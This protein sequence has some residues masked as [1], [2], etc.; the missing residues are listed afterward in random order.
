[1]T[2]EKINVVELK[3]D[4]AVHDIQKRLCDYSD[5]YI[6][7]VITEIADS[8]VDIYYSDLFE[9]A[10]NNWSYIDDA[11]REFGMPDS[12][13]TNII[14]KLIQQGQFYYNEELL[15]DDLDNMLLNF[16][17]SYLLHDL[18]IEEITK[19]QQEAIEEKCTNVDNNDRLDDYVDFLNELFNV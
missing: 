11:C 9:W 4:V 18:K 1:M 17:Y 19:E 5:G 12:K 10:K 2:N 6:C 16:C 3:N 14:I 15:Y 8:D 7:D 13:D